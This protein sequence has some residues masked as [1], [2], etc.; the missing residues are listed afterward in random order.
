MSCHGQASNIEVHTFQGS[1]I[2]VGLVDK[3]LLHPRLHVYG[4]IWYCSPCIGCKPMSNEVAMSNQEGIPAVSILNEQCI[5]PSFQFEKPHVAPIGPPGIPN[6]PKFHSSFLAPSN[7][8][9]IMVYI[10]YRGIASIL[11]YSITIPAR[12]RYQ[13]SSKCYETV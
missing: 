4:R 2:V 3:F 5:F 11:P 13:S 8:F 12:L 6:M 1:R 7:N 10:C 9:H